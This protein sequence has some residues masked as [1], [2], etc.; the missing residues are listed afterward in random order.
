MEIVYAAEKDS[1]ASLISAHTRQTVHPDDIRLRENPA[2][3][4]S[5]Y[6]DWNLHHYTLAPGGR[7]TENE[8]FLVE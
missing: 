7:I 5:F 4:G 3:T 6:I 1:I 2:E 8:L